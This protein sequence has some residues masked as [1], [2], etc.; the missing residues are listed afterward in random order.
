MSVTSKVVGTTRASAVEPSRTVHGCELRAGDLRA[1]IWNFGA[2]LVALDAPDRDGVVANV[3]ARHDDLSGY[4]DPDARA[5][6]LGATV[7]RWANRIRGGRCTVDGRD[8]VLE[9]NDGA[10]HLH[11]G[12]GFDQRI[13]TIQEVAGDAGTAAD[14]AAIEAS[15]VSPDGD[16]GYPGRLEVTVTF[17]LS[18]TQLT[19]DYTATS[20]A[21]TPIN[22][23]NHA[24]WNLAGGG[25]IDEH[26]VRIPASHYLPVDEGSIPVGGP[27]S[28][29][30]TRFDFRTERPLG[31]FVGD[32]IAVGYDHCLLPDGEGLRRVAE[33]VDPVSGRTMV[34]ETDQPGVQLYTANYLEPPHTALCLET[35]RAPDA[36]NQPELGPSLLEPGQTYRHTTVHTFGVR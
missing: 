31:P 23:T 33:V 2:T 15:L 25:R 26:R 6:Y 24:Y 19:I 14:T 20:D 22:L 12:V 9:T 30:G 17:T 13:W 11:G 7:G 5:G 27:A 1:E 18:P 28:V 29:E 10:H 35:Q 16:A 8:V 34:V 3:V 32:P 36:V 21:V 4:D